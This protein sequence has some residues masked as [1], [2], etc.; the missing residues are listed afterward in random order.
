MDCTIGFLQAQ[1]NDFP[2]S[3]VDGAEACIQMTGMTQF[4][5]SVRVRSIDNFIS[6]VRE[7]VI[8]ANSYSTSVHVWR[9]S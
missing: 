7:F 6:A 2:E 4:D 3:D 1:V 8:Y 9:K 5:I